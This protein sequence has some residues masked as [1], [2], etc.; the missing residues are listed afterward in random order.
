M[1]A[2]PATSPFRS[3]LAP[4][5]ESLADPDTRDPPAFFHDLNLD[6]VVTAIVSRWKEYDLS[7]FFFAAPTNLDTIAY[8]Q[9]VMKDLEHDVVARCIASFAQRMRSMRAHLERVRQLE[10]KYE[11]QRWFLNAVAVYCEAVRRLFDDLG[12]V[13]LSAQ[14]LC[15]F[16]DY[17]DR[18]AASTRFQELSSGSTQL[19]SDLEA[20]RYAVVISGNNVTVVDYADEIDYAAD[21]EATFEKFRRGTTKDYRVKFTDSGRLNHVEAEI[22]DRVALL[23]PRVFTALDTFCTRHAEYL[24]GAVARFDR[25]VHFYVAYHDFIAHLKG[26]GLPFCYPDVSDTSK[27]VEGRDAFDVALAAS[28]VARRATVV[29]NDFEL[30]AGE[31]VF[32]ITGPNQGG[33][34]TFARMFG[35]MH[36]LASLGCPVPGSRA[37]LFL[38]DRLFSHFEREEDI[39]DRRGKLQDDLIRI[40]RILDNASASSIV[41]LNEVFASTALEDAVLLSKKVMGAIAELDLLAVC[42]TFLDE[43]AAFNDKTVSIVGGVDPNDP[44]IRT[45]KLERRPADGLAYAL[46]IAEKHHV[47]YGSLTRRLRT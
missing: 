47:T 9:A 44:S 6:Q 8:R 38:F 7:P 5:T 28:L 23:H 2:A 35:Q 21:V 34:T 43:L 12:R 29:C 14:G 27:A 45:F 31:R 4:P 15:E 16:R 3:I 33:K 1:T 40:R 25:E 32:V 36:Y 19:V 17:L 20:I 10:Y 22:L 24:D 18:Y 46:A 41:I 11:R 30:R 39:S 37:R 26:A 42:V 13:S